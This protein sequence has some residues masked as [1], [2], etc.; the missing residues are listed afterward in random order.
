MG[1]KSTLKYIKYMV[2]PEYMMAWR[3]SLVD[4]Q[5]Q[6]TARAGSGQE[7]CTFGSRLCSTLSLRMEFVTHA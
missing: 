4:S 1:D 5:K 6:K 2:E 7:H 3:A